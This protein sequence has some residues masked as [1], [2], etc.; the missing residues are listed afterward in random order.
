MDPRRIGPVAA[1]AADGSVWRLADSIPR[2][3]RLASNGSI[4]IDVPLQAAELTAIR[5]RQLYEIESGSLEP[6]VRY[7]T[8]VQLVAGAPWVLLNASVEEGA[9]LLLFEADG[10][11]RGSLFLPATEGGRRFVVD[12]AQARAYFVGPRPPQQMTATASPRAVSKVAT[13][14]SRASPQV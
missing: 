8:D 7:A 2:L 3:R 13:S 5:V 6:P 14:S 1:A 10:T 11:Q 9:V 4:E 12:T